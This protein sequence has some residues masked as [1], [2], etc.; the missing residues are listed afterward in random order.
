MQCPKCGK[1]MEISYDKGGLILYKCQSCGHMKM[2]SKDREQ[3][4]ERDD[5]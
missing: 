4:W 3:D 1:A 2:T 5:V